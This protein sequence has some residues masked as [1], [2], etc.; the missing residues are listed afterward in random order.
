ML[1]Y[2]AQCEETQYVLVLLS[3]SWIFSV[4]NCTFEA[5]EY[6][7]F[8]CALT[9]PILIPLKATMNLVLTS[10]MLT[11]SKSTLTDSDTSVLL[12]NWLIL[13]LELES[14]IDYGIRIATGG[15]WFEH[16]S[17][18]LWTWNS[19]SSVGSLNYGDD[20]VANRWTIAM[21]YSRH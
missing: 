5:P 11:D 6:K 13:E 9:F 7:W 14:V 8:P 16:S 1:F 18:H 15:R 10:F 4:Y 20:S 17:V 19:A 3:I 21:R 12:L 2:Q